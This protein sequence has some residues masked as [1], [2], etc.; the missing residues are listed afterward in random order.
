MSTP[1]LAPASAPF[2]TQADFDDAV[3]RAGQAAALYY[4]G[5]TQTLTDADYDDLVER[6]AATATANPTWAND[7][8]EAILGSVA[9]GASAGGDVTHPDR[10]LSLGKI[11]P[12]TAG[13]DTNKAEAAAL[14]VKAPSGVVV[15]P[16]MDGLAIRVEYVEGRLFLAATRGDGMTGEN[17]TEQVRRGV[18]GL[19][20]TLSERFT[21]EVRGEVYMTEA[22]FAQAQVLR[23][24]R[25]G[26]PF[27][28]PRN[29]TA[30]CLR[31]SGAENA[32]PLSFAAY[33][34]T[35]TLT[36]HHDRMSEA[37]G[38]GLGTARA[39]VTA[40]GLDL[41]PVT[42][43]Q[44]AVDLITAIEALRPTLGFDIDGAVVKADHDIDRGALGEGSRTPHWAIAYKYPPQQGTSR[45]LDIEVRTGRTGRISLRARIE[46]VFVGGTTITYASVHNPSW[47]T[48]QGIGV[49]SAVLVERR[50][51]VIPRIEA[52]LD[53]AANEGIATWVAPEACPTCGETWDKTS[54]LWRCH[55]PSCSVVGRITYFASRDCMDVEGLGES[56]ATALVE[57]DLVTSIADLY[58]LTLAQWAT[59]P[60]GDT[61]RHLGTRVLGETVARKIM[62]NLEA[63]KAQP[64]N[65][66]I[67]AL[68]IRMTGRSV[69]RWLASAHPTMD[70]LRAASIE[71]IASIERLGAIKATYIVNGLAAMSTVI[72][73]LAAAG[74]NMGTEPVADDSPKPL[75]GKSV[76]I[77]GAVPAGYKNRTEAQEAIEAAG[78]KA[79]GSVSKTTSYLVTDETTTSKAKKA[80]SLGV[81]VI[82]PADF[83]ALLRGEI[84]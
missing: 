57:A 64:F 84:A 31:K 58:D 16:K 77:S 48:E 53:P 23:A 60:V 65:R 4:D 2:L 74:V 17:V 18:E 43:A 68:G 41:A 81:P 54:L 19:P 11:S 10:M 39:T 8:S 73:R 6:I 20:L 24:E 55:T 42:E 7:D 28:N 50:G 40:R 75:A 5:E 46:P 1:S 80:A 27:V 56:I 15:E 36:S 63:S 35:S 33:D 70:R 76:V 71:D 51:D 14:V 12:D 44:G 26:K 13:E 38:L 69:G 29:A 3:A 62:S 66:V 61:G 37:E 30:G 47:I 49:G 45:I 78:G 79:S 21:G 22:Q 34:L 25:G 82:D 32:M 59:L 52:P 9:A 72:D 67:T 83:A